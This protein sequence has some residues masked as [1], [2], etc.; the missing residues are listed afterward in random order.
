[1]SAIRVILFDLGG[2]LLPFDRERRIA[3]IVER[4]GVTPEAA[5]AFMASDIHPR[6]DTGEAGEE[7]LAAA[8]S[9]FA[10]RVM[11]LEEAR[12]LVLSVFEAP[13]RPL[14]DLAGALRERFVVGGFSDN[15]AFVRRMFPPGAKL[16]PM[17]WSSEIGA[18]KPSPKAF[19]A[20]R[21]H[22]AA[23]PETILFIDDGLANVEQ[24]RRMGWEAIG[25]AS[26]DQLAAELAARGLA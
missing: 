15:P 1:M 17:F 14:W 9:V 12:D 4:L 8:F 6:L 24:A 10:G 19:E 26:N 11:P 5:R 16:E 22:L 25:F 23:P 2:V 20:V 13:N 3:A 21:A 7:A 18:L